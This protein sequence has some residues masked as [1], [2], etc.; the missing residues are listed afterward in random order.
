MKEVVWCFIYRKATTSTENYKVA[1]ELWRER[2]RNLRTN[3]D[4]KLLLNQKYYI[5]KSKKIT[6]NEIDQIKENIRHHMQDNT[7]NNIREE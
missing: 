6:D 1:Y 2:N 7:E 3:I 5:L 4:A